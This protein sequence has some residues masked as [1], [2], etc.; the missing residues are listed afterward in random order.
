[1]KELKDLEATGTIQLIPPGFWA[2]IAINLLLIVT[3]VFLMF[4]L[5]I[6]FNIDRK[7]L[8]TFILF[9]PIVLSFILVTPSFL[10]IKGFPKFV[11]VVKIFALLIFMFSIAQAF[12]L[13]QK[14]ATFSNY[15]LIILALLNLYLVYSRPF[16]VF[17]LYSAKVREIKL[18]EY[19]EYKKE[20]QKHRAEK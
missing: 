5:G 12:Y 1:M 14:T 2:F 6:G 17:Y 11:T 20:L 7:E 19:E 9:S 13:S 10:V 15:S 18:E 3:T 4:K 8:M 16:K